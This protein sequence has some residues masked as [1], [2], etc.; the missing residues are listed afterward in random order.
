METKK[1]IVGSLLLLGG[2]LHAQKIESEE[3]AWEEWSCGEEVYGKAT[4]IY[5]SDCEESILINT[6]DAKIEETTV[7]G[8]ITTT[9]SV[10]IKPR[11]GTRIRIIPLSLVLQELAYDN[12]D[13]DGKVELR[14][15]KVGS[16]QDE[17]AK[18]G[19]ESASDADL[20]I[21]PNPVATV[22]HIETASPIL[23]YSVIDTYG[24][25]RLEGETLADGQL[26]VSSLSTGVYY[27]SIETTTQTLSKTF[28]K[29]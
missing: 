5:F 3:P 17:E 18:P 2:F 23:R 25:I 27:L 9:E 20:M 15:T 14:S 26:S 16:N 19:L 7:S 29:N 28:Y 12:S 4:G 1:A 24:I 11:A 21:Y 6:L 22:L 8:T 13:L 10:S